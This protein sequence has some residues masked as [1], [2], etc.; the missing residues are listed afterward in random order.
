M[1]FAAGKARIL[2]KSA[3]AGFLAQLVGVMLVVCA[4]H[5]E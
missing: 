5:K 2:D 3:V 1:P 4:A